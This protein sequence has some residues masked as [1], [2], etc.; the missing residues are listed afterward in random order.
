[1]STMSTWK[2]RAILF[3]VILAVAPLSAASHAQDLDEAVVVNV[4]FAFQNGSQHFT[5]G[6]YTIRI[7]DQ[8]V[9]IIQGKSS[10]GFAISW[11]HEE[12][13]LPSKTTR[14]V[15]QRYG[16]QYV[17]HE[18]WVTGETSYTYFLPSK[19]EKRELAANRD[20]PTGV[21]V[22]ALEMPLAK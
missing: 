19:A 8:H 21:V 6:L 13:S 5:A 1:M 10:S 12:D 11:L 3:T 4:P 22:A 17:L 20:A 15:F 18:V 2:L 9:M 7:E 14:V 16:D